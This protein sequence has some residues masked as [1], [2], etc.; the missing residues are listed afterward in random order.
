MKAL[1]RIIQSVGRVFLRIIT[2]GR[3]GHRVTVTVEDDKT[4][5]TIDEEKEDN[6]HE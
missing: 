2:L 6:N 5:V 4:T 1:F 3:K